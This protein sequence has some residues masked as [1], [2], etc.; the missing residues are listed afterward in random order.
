M[1][2]YYAQRRASLKHFS[3]LGFR[4]MAGAYYVGGGEKVRHFRGQK[5]PVEWLRLGYGGR[6]RRAAIV[7]QDGL[8]S[9]GLTCGAR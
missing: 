3:E 7:T 5:A 4:T 2:W 6:R 8:S 9:E 1:C